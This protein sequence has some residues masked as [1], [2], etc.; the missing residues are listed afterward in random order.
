MR[1][2]G[3]LGRKPRKDKRVNVRMEEWQLLLLKRHAEFCEMSL[4]ELMIAGA[5]LYYERELF[6][7]NPN[8]HDDDV[9]FYDDNM[10][11]I[12]QDAID[13]QKYLDGQDNLRCPWDVDTK[14]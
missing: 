11:D 2:K 14:Q 3:A 5:F 8:L 13:E 1:T 6:K 9:I 4:S 7:D 12:Y 10:S